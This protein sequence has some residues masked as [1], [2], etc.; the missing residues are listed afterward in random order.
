MGGVSG[1]LNFTITARGIPSK[2]SE[3][4]VVNFGQIFTKRMAEEAS[5]SQVLKKPWP[6]SVEAIFKFTFEECRRSVGRLEKPLSALA[7]TD[8]AELSDQLDSA[9]VQHAIERD[10]RFKCCTR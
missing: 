1:G 10:G 5:R 4:R 2:E 6:A 8:R 9:T 3:T 7:V